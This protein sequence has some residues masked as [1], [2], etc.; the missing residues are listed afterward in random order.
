MIKVDKDDIP[1]VI[2]DL[3]EYKDGYRA[4]F[5]NGKTKDFKYT[6]VRSAIPEAYITWL[7]L[8]NWSKWYPQ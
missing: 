8:T 4:V 7:A 5:F 6:E 3:R 2:Q 1:R